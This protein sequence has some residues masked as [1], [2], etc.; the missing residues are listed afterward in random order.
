MVEHNVI[1]LMGGRRPL[2]L[3]YGARLGLLGPLGSLRLEGS[4]LEWSLIHPMTKGAALSYFRESAY[5]I[6]NSVAHYFRPRCLHD[7]LPCE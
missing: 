2:R 6:G 3:D 5:C 7:G 4:P 1:G